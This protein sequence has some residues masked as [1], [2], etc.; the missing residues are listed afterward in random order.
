MNDTITP[1]SMRKRIY[2]FL[3]AEG[4]DVNDA[5]HKV[6]SNLIKLAC[7][8]Q[9]GEYQNRIGDLTS[10]LNNR[11]IALGARRKD[12]VIIAC[13]NKEMHIARRCYFDCKV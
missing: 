13:S 12:N 5:R 10:K 11:E 4:F 3:R 1:G 6:L 7:S 8:A 2:D 9:L